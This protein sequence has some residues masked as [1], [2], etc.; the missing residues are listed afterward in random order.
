MKAQRSILTFLCASVL[1]AL[2]GQALAAT[3]TQPVPTTNT[4]AARLA[5]RYTDFAGSDT[6]ALALVDGLRNGT[7]ITLDTTSIVKN[8]NGTTSTVSTPITFQP[9]THK[10][11]YGNVNI[12]LALARDDLTKLGIADPTAA[13]IQAALN[14]GSVQL[15]D[16]SIRAL[17]GVLALRAQDEGWGQVSKNMGVKL[18]SVVSASNTNHSQASADHMQNHQNMASA[19]R[20]EH[21]IHPDRPQR[22]DIPQ[23]PDVPHRPDIPDH[24]GIPGH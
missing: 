12:A 18:G 2:G 20:P 8:A 21:P 4:E 7:S 14:G 17:Q 22:P 1:T 10:M 3:G 16:G 11:G 15:A 24:A 23:H 19:N 6:N 5:T 13:E 9:A